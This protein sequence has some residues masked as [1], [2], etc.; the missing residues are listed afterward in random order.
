[1]KYYGSKKI[2][3]SYFKRYDGC[4]SMRRHHDNSNSLAD[5]RLCESRRLLCSALRFYTESLVSFCGCGNRIRPCRSPQR[6]SAVA[7]FLIKG[8]VALCAY[9]LN[10]TVLGKNALGRIGCGILSEI[11]MIFGYFGFSALLRGKGLAAA[12]SIPGNIVQALCGVACSCIL[13]QLINRYHLLE[14]Y[15]KTGSKSTK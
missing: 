12:A 3:K 10:R 2:E 1:M 14:H 7:T 11:I 8:C 15:Y 6:L 5:K 4:L 9:I 13:I